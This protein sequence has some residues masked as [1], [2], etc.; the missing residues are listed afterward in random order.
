MLQ[1]IFKRRPQGVGLL[2]PWALVGLSLG[3]SACVAGNGETSSSSLSA[4]QFSSVTAS[5]Q[6]AV[7]SSAVA[8]SS[9]E[10][11]ALNGQALYGELCAGCHGD[12][13]QGGPLYE[14]PIVTGN[15][16]FEFLAHDIIGLTMPYKNPEKCVDDCAE[17]IATYLGSIRGGFGSGGLLAAP[18]MPERDVDI[19]PVELRNLTKVE[20]DNTVRDLFHTTKTFGHTFPEEQANKKGF[21]TLGEL[22]VVNSSWVEAHEAAIDS[23][24]REAMGGLSANRLQHFEIELPPVIRAARGSPRDGGLWSQLVYGST[25]VPFVAE[26]SGNYEISLRA[27]R[28]GPGHDP[29]VVFNIDNLSRGDIFVPAPMEKMN[30]YAIRTDLNAGPYELDLLY[31]N[32]LYVPAM[33]GKPAEDLNVVYDWVRIEGPLAPYRLTQKPAEQ[34]RPSAGH[35]DGDAW[36]M[37][38]PGFWSLPIAAT[39]SGR[40]RL[41]VKAAEH[42]LGDEPSKLAIKQ[43][44]NTLAVIDVTANIENFAIYSL[45]VD[46]PRGNYDLRLDFI[47]DL[48][49]GPG[50][51]RNLLVDWVSI[52]GPIRTPSKPRI[53]ELLCTVDSLNAECARE[54][55]AQFGEKAWRRPLNDQELDELVAV[56]QTARDDGANFDYGLYY[57][58]R[59]LMLSQNFLY[60]PERVTSKVPVALNDYELASRLSYFL[61][62]SMPDAELMLHAK[63]GELQNDDILRTQVKRMLKDPKSEALVKIFAAQWIRFDGIQ[64]EE[65]KKNLPSLE[66]A[67]EFN[68]A[69]VNSLV[70][71]TE[72]FLTDVFTNNL[73]VETL[74]TADFTYVDNLVA[75]YYG[76]SGAGDGFAKVSAPDQR[77]GLLGQASLLT[78]TSAPKNTVPPGRGKYVLET[79]LCSEPEPAPANA[80]SISDVAAMAGETTRQRL[81]RHRQDPACANC[82]ILMDP[83][84]FGLENFDLA[85]RWREMDNGALVD[86]RGVLPTGETFEGAIE[87]SDLLK[88]SYLLPMC[89]MQNAMTYGLG[90]EI[91]GINGTSM[92]EDYAA[93][94]DIYQQTVSSNHAIHDVLE[95][96]VLSSLFRQSKM[97][98]VAGE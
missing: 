4:E 74:I 7:S 82:H 55:L 87:L 58:L 18:K 53:A 65:G 60:R 47:N 23:L 37:N 88:E 45:D 50:Q 92:G 38:S 72:Y 28:E 43:G 17:A 46:L 1:I 25:F 66:F 68:E 9:S 16:T 15:Y 6:P 95:T 39:E 75:N 42:A 90:R 62:S 97:Q 11:T 76:V 44:N 69:L 84:G 83:L 49:L 40:Y 19:K 48:Y 20:F 32:D 30:V 12:S 81:L 73:P 2:K 10:A 94:Y 33:D 70:A 8:Q 22:Q 26:Q 61:W 57:S 85:G 59:A 29:H 54:I 14:D 27:G 71:E 41:R 89:F 91:H 24:I 77:R 96:I 3:L 35:P 13:G 5:S 64:S 52:E 51:D 31:D 78:L 21:N 63:A 36:N 67:P 98:A 56:Y 93:V 86:S 79:F 34:L 80:G